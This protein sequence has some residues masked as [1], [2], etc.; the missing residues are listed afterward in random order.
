MRERVYRVRVDAFPDDYDYQDTGCDIAP[1]CLRCP[2][3]FCRYDVAGGS[4]AIRAA[5]TERKV[6]NLSRQGKRK[7]QAK[8]QTP[9]CGQRRPGP[10]TQINT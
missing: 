3:E 1:S 4:A 5:S 9:S 10:S 7:A 2:L 8:L 6:A